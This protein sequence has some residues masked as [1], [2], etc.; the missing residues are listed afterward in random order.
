[1]TSAS[2]EAY[3]TGRGKSGQ[4]RAAHRLTAGRQQ[5]LVPGTATYGIRK[6]DETATLRVAIS[7]K[8]ASEGCSSEREGRERKS[9]A[10]M[11]PSRLMT[12]TLAQSGYPF[13]GKA[14]NPAYR[15]AVFVFF[16]FIFAYRS[17][18]CIFAAKNLKNRRITP[19]LLLVFG[20]LCC[21]K[22]AK[23]GKSR[24]CCHTKR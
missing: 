14:Q 15:P 6:D 19:S 8:P 12:D 17:K 24:L 22:V 7:C 5:C 1:M 3:F 20:G 9:D 13:S 18:K 10:A 23:R 2:S 4:H 21:Q 16:Y 11:H